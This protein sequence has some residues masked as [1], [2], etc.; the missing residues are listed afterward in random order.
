MIDPSLFSLSVTEHQAIEQLLA[1]VGSDPSLEQLWWLMDQSWQACG[2]DNLH[3][4]ADRYAVFYHHPVWLLNGMFIEQHSVSMGHRRAITAAV[5]ALVP[6]RVVDV[7]GGFGT[8]ARLMASALPA[9]TVHICEPYPPQHGIESCQPYANIQFVPDLTSE[10]YDVLVSTD[11]LEHVPDA[12]ALLA[13]MVNAVRPGGHLLIANCF[14]SS[15]PVPPALHLSP[16][17]QF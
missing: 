11:V 7:G 1:E 10:A 5:A 14:F 4:D 12:L 15:D 8:L 3:V 17:P 16:A 13:R 9:T 2:C 6:Q